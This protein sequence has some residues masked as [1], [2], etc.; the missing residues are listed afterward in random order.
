M[1]NRIVEFLKENNLQDKT[2]ILGFSGGYDS[3]CLL[4]ILS[5]N[6]KN[7]PIL[8]YMKDNVHSDSVDLDVIDFCNRNG[9]A[10]FYYNG[11]YMRC[12]SKNP[13]FIV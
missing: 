8:S 12:Q 10:F 5:K 1:I 13:F 4:D 2:V 7:E 6:Q 11:Y 9:I 3:M